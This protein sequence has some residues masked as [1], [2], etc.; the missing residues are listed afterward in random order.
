[1]NKLSTDYKSDDS[2][3]PDEG[4][5]HNLKV[6]CSKN[7]QP[8]NILYANKGYINSSHKNLA[9]KKFNSLSNIRN[10]HS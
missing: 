7:M 9:M 3:I 5:N 8:A 2:D 6:N 1:M 10:I 4:V